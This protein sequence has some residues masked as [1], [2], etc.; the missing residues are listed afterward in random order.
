MELGE[1]LDAFI[2]CQ[3]VK[4]A[5]V[6]CQL[7]KIEAAMAACAMA[8]QKASSVQTCLVF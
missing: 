3:L 1:H 7:F 6:L 4:I 8:W 2:L 5:A